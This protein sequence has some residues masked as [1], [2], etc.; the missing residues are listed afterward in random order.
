MVFQCSLLY[1]L[2]QVLGNH[3]L[4][5]CKHMSFFFKLV[6]PEAIRWQVYKTQKISA[7]LQKSNS[8]QVL[9]CLF[10][11]VYFYSFIY[12]QH[13]ILVVGLS[14]VT[15]TWLWDL[16]F[17]ACGSLVAA[18]GIQFPDQEPNLGPLHWELGVLAARP[19]GKP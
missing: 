4:F 13:Q 10:F 3:H 11:S 6:F 12:F 18:C 5:P 16:L 2:Y 8:V 15:P 17:T 9:T 19:P 1:R 14:C 7:I